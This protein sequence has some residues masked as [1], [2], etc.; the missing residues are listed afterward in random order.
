MGELEEVEAPFL[1]FHSERDAW[2]DPLGSRALYERSRSADKTLVAV[3]HMCVGSLGRQGGCAAGA[4]AS[5]GLNLVCVRAG[6][7]C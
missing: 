3:D 2:T 5:H 4:G 1:V 7:T 6:F